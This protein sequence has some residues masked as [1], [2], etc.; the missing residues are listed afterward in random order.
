MR[1][2]I[3]A[4]FSIVL[5]SLLVKN[6]MNK[7]DFKTPEEIKFL[8]IIFFIAVTIL[9]LQYLWISNFS[10]SLS[11]THISSVI[12]CTFHRLSI[13]MIEIRN[14]LPDPSEYTGVTY[15]YD[16]SDP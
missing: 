8:F 9:I 12:N 2:V 1:I 14:V 6:K 13:M 10:S 4:I 3:F 11:N 5:A 15:G 16:G 7:I